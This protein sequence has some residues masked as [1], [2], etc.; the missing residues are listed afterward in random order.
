MGPVLRREVG[1]WR[2]P[3]T[4]TGGALGRV[5]VSDAPAVACEYLDRVGQGSDW[6]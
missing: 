1:A 5:E 4:S 3:N 6:E 2:S